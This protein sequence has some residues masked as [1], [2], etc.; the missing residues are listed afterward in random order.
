MSERAH[1]RKRTDRSP[2]RAAAAP[3]ASHG[4]SLGDIG[5]DEEVG[6]MAGKPQA[7]L[8][9]PLSGV[10]DQSVEYV[11]ER[12]P[13]L[14]GEAIAPR[15]LDVS[16]SRPH[17]RV[18]R[19]ATRRQPD[20]ARPAVGGIRMALDVSQTFEFSQQI[21]R[22][23]LGQARGRCDFARPTPI[24]ACEPE[25]SDHRRRDLGVPRRVNARQ[26]SASSKVIGEAQSTD[27][28]RDAVM[29][30]RG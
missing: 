23:L 3:T 19:P 27:R 21:V 1:P 10:C 6:V 5:R 24:N 22:R 14:I 9:S 15:P 20:D 13:V 26:H 25:E 18:E 12:R 30:R 17:G 29:L 16:P 8:R 7:S 28:A 11:V 4:R 2:A